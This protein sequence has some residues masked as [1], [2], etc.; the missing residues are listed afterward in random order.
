LHLVPSSVGDRAARYAITWA[1]GALR[2]T[3]LQV[4]VKANARTGLGSPD[5]FY[6]GN[7]IGDSGATPLRVDLQDYFAARA[8]LGRPGGGTADPL[9]FD[10]DGRVT[11][12]DLL[13][14]RRNLGNRLPAVQAP[15]AAATHP[16]APR[17]RSAYELLSAD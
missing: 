14:V 3:W 1:N 8:A 4:T 9:D 6:F 13:A 2:N 10:R 15:A 16:G 5:V 17:R 7:L 12:V 11:S